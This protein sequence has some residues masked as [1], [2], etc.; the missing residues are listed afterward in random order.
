MI[1]VYIKA[2]RAIT[3]A[4]EGS[5]SG[6][7][8]YYQGINPSV[9]GAFLMSD[10][11]DVILMP[12]KYYTTPDPDP[13]SVA[14]LRYISL[15]PTPSPA[16]LNDTI[17]V[18]VQLKQSDNST[19]LSEVATVNINCDMGLLSESSV[20]TTGLG[21][22]SFTCM[23]SKGGKVTILASANT[24]HNASTTVSLN[25]PDSPVKQNWVESNDLKQGIVTAEKTTVIERDNIYANLA[26]S[27]NSI[28]VDGS[29]VYI[30][31]HQDAGIND[32]V[33]Q[34]N[35]TTQQIPYSYS[36]SGSNLGN[37]RDGMDDETSY[38]WVGSGG[39]LYKLTKADMTAN[40]PFNPL[41]LDSGGSATIQF[42]VRDTTNSC[43]W[44]HIRSGTTYTDNILKI[45]DTTGSVSAN[46]D[47]T[48]SA[49][50]SGI[51]RQKAVI[52][53]DYLYFCS[54]DAGY[55]WFRVH[56]STNAWSVSGNAGGDYEEAIT[57]DGTSIWIG[58]DDGIRCDES[59]YYTGNTR[60]YL[61]ATSVGIVYNLHYS[62][63]SS[64]VWAI[65]STPGGDTTRRWL[66]EFTRGYDWDSTL[67][68]NVPHLRVGRVVDIG[69]NPSSYAI[70]PNDMHSES[71]YLYTAN[72]QTT[73]GATY[74]KSNITKVRIS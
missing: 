53:G 42:V 41:V 10:D 36:Y 6:I 31:G 37:H 3:S 18:N 17:T 45:D 14:A 56:T 24:F 60:S 67:N 35:H 9:I 43:I 1:I 22:A 50:Y 70:V 54:S 12:R 44:V 64:S 2:T 32:R 49:T 55:R 38:L 8:S 21:A 73:D 68:A 59:F 7:L 23:P 25:I 62:S 47:T 20:V 40:S 65:T 5:D 34:V 46:I 63:S 29:Y 11:E 72:R 57:S 66:R 61:P 51:N 19:N 30:N 26:D 27:G 69:T 33:R 48:Q 58:G 71:G 16:D 39:D 4:I 52:L 74:S 28:I 15:T 13:T